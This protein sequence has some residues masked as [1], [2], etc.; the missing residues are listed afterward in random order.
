M[1]HYPLEKSKQAERLLIFLRTRNPL[2]L[3]YKDYLNNR[4]RCGA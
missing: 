1:K 4:D 3:T 2:R